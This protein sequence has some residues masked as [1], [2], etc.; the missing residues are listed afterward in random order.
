M[1]GQNVTP[2]QLAREVCA[3][4]T[5][6]SDCLLGGRCRLADS[7]TCRYFR[8]SVLPLVGKVARYGR[9]EAAYKKSQ[10]QASRQA[11]DALDWARNAGDGTAN[12]RCLNCL[13]GHRQMCLSTFKLP[14]ADTQGEPAVRRIVA[15][16]CRTCKAPIYTRHDRYCTKAC[17][18]A[19]AK[20]RRRQNR[21]RANEGCHDRRSKALVNTGPLKAVS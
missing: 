2:F 6:A 18:K 7:K 4:F 12:C 15:S 17:L 10:A 13:N 9:V 3:N 20:E 1:G 11:A 21:A 14:G 5:G 19:A 16:Y 8:E